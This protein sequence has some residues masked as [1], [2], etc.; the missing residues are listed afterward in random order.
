MRYAAECSPNICLQEDRRV[1]VVGSMSPELLENVHMIQ[2]SA[3][4]MLL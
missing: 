1:N 2:L 3:V 4:P